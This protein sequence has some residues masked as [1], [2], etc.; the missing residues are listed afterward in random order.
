MSLALVTINKVD[1]ISECIGLF[2]LDPMYLLLKISVM[3]V[4]SAA[5]IFNP[6]MPSGNK[7]VTH[8]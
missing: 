1:I 5:L 3:F 7:K 2:T 6:L 8:T 4:M